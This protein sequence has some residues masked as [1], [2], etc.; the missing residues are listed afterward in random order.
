M[1]FRE[2]RFSE[3]ACVR[4][5]EGGRFES[6]WN[7]SLLSIPPDRS[8]VFNAGWVFTGAFPAALLLVHLPVLPPTCTPLGL[9]LPPPLP[10][11]AWF[12]L[13]PPFFFGFSSCPQASSARRTGTRIS[14][15]IVIVIV[16]I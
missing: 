8:P 3:Q 15:G 9:S 2:L 7:Q 5:V 11:L 10:L 16:C 6:S 13:L 1:G 4:Q 12:L 14:K